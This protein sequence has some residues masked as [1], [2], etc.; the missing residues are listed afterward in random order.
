MERNKY[1]EVIDHYHRLLMKGTIGRETALWSIHAVILCAMKD[2]RISADD[3]YCICGYRN[4]LF[5]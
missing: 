4:R 3:Y 5:K 1:I 2:Y